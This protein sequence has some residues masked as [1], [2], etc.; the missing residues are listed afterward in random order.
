LGE[1]LDIKYANIGGMEGAGLY[2]ADNASYSTGYGH[3][4]MVA[5]KQCMQM[6]FCFVVVGSSCDH[7]D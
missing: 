4:V 7:V 1:G 3:P 5:G 2:F 6:L